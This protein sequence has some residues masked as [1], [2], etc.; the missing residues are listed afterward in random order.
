[1]QATLVCS[2]RMLYVTLSQLPVRMTCH[3]LVTHSQIEVQEKTFGTCPL[4]SLRCG[5]GLKDPAYMH[6]RSREKVPHVGDDGCPAR[7]L[8]QNESE[9]LPG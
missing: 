1:M 2:R 5:V 8:K 9:P 6:E 3:N 7:L 4:H